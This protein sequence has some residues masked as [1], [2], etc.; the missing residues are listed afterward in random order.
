VRWRCVD[1][2]AE[3]ARRF[4]VEIHESTVGR[5]LHE[6]GLTRLQ[7]RPSHPRKA[8]RRK[9]P[10]KKLRPLLTAALPARALGGPI[11][12]WFQDEARVGH[13]STHAY[14]WHDRLATADGAR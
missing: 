7:P 6:Q 9:R 12:V 5:W 2:Q 4:D 10:L 11:E 3:V 14:I 1:L 8:P 13:K